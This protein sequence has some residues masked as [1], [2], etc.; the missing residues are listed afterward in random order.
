MEQLYLWDKRKESSQGKSRVLLRSMSNWAGLPM[1]RLNRPARW[2]AAE[3]SWRGRTKKRPPGA[4]SRKSM[5]VFKKEFVPHTFLFSFL[6]L[7]SSHLPY[8]SPFTKGSTFGDRESRLS[9]LTPPLTSCVILSKFLTSL[10]LSLLNCK[11]GSDISSCLIGFLQE[12][13][14]LIL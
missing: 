9:V 13:S 12:S 2:A 11:M 14:G 4:G 6:P 1:L 8:S 10:S 3:E 5:P 7:L